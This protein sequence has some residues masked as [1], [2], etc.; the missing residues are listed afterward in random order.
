M[1]GYTALSEAPLSDLPDGGAPTTYVAL[2]GQSCTATAG[3][4]QPQLQQQLVATTQQ[5][6]LVPQV[7][8]TLTGLQC[9]ASS[10]QFMPRLSG[11]Q[12]TISQGVLTPTYGVQLTGLQMQTYYHSPGYINA[13]GGNVTVGLIG[14]GMAVSQ[15]ALAGAVTV[16][17]NATTFSPTPAVTT[18]VSSTPAFNNALAHLRNQS[19]LVR[20]EAY[21]FVGEQEDGAA[22]DWITILSSPSVDS[23]VR[24]LPDVRTFA[25]AAVPNWGELS[26][27]YAV[28]DIN[29]KLNGNRPQE[30]DDSG[31]EYDGAPQNWGLGM[32]LGVGVEG[33]VHWL[34][35]RTFEDTP[36][37][38]PDVKRFIVWEVMYETDEAATGFADYHGLEVQHDIDMSL[39][40]SSSAEQDG[41][42]NH[43]MG[44]VPLRDSKLP[45]GRSATTQYH[46]KHALVFYPSLWNDGTN[47]NWV[48]TYT[49]V[50]K[51]LNP[52]VNVQ[53]VTN[54]VQLREWTGVTS[55]WAMQHSMVTVHSGYGN[56]AYLAYLASTSGAPR[57]PS[58][59]GLIV[60]DIESQE[61][62][63]HEVKALAAVTTP[64]TTEDDQYQEPNPHRPMSQ[65][66]KLSDGRSV[67]QFSIK[68]YVVNLS[69]TSGSHR[70]PTFSTKAG[71]STGTLCSGVDFLEV[72]GNTVY[73]VFMRGNGVTPTAF[74]PVYNDA[75]SPTDA[76]WTVPGS[77]L[78]SWSLTFSASSKAVQF[79]SG[80]SKGKQTWFGETVY[81]NVAP[82]YLGDSAFRS[83]EAWIDFWANQ[84]P[85]LTVEA[86]G[87]VGVVETAALNNTVSVQLV[88]HQLTT[89]LT[90]GLISGENKS[91]ALTGQQ[92]YVGFTSPGGV[93]HVTVPLVGHS[94]EASIGQIGFPGRSVSVLLDGL[95][96]TM[97]MNTPSSLPPGT[98]QLAGF[99]ATTQRGTLVPHITVA[100][101]GLS[102][103][104][105]GGMLTPSTPLFNG[106]QLTASAG[107]L[108]PTVGATLT[109]Q[110]ATPAAG[111]LTPV[112][113]G[114]PSG[115]VATTQRGTITPHVSV[116]LVGQ[117]CTVSQGTMARVV[118]PTLTGQVATASG[119]AFGPALSIPI[120]GRSATVSAGLFIPL[121][122]IPLQGSTLNVQRGSFLTFMSVVLNGQ[123]ALTQQGSVGIISDAF[124]TLTGV[125]GRGY[126]GPFETN[127]PP[128]KQDA[129]LWVRADDDDTELFLTLPT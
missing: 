3:Q 21:I 104:A 60:M 124:V 105:S 82:N 13:T 74:R 89:Y 111:T 108:V 101:T 69:W 54:D 116:Q 16:G 17:T 129:D 43:A 29:P 27:Y 18:N 64:F 96:M 98:V 119:G 80:S 19:P 58:Y 9:S 4:L 38:Y 31:L 107:T 73:H 5:G 36:Y 126:I 40:E 15:G 115:Q 99:Q 7:S 55:L 71:P 32:M 2:T 117:S 91:V 10:G 41:P 77:D 6:T 52:V 26:S 75:T 127:A 11:Q 97:Q 28:Q 76:S 121:T 37:T 83:G 22:G 53:Q 33:T 81:D 78:W 118:G 48:P 95:S 56:V 42:V 93:Q 25:F 23:V 59:V 109:G 51:D 120:T 44:V 68:G 61:V 85:V 14:H 70:H 125:E 79:Y 86:E 66:I 128:R 50:S 94:M 65:A 57:T 106:L 63:A 45:L 67:T 62:F 92:V 35:V 87:R 39:Y 47:D 72:R 112:V 30:F 90:N 49:K 84:N 12:L 34:R 103:T 20:G 114:K 24:V 100:L 88:G 110:V 122:T 113:A 46:V 8:V 102:C 1:L 123:A